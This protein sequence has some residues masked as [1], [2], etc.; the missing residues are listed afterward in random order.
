MDR[1]MSRVCWIHLAQIQGCPTIHAKSFYFPLDNANALGREHALKQGSGN[2]Q[3]SP[4]ILNKASASNYPADKAALTNE[5]ETRLKR[6][7]QQVSKPQE[8]FP[9]G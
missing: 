9:S 2:S 4:F 7:C 3:G 8:V 1:R 5:S 6:K